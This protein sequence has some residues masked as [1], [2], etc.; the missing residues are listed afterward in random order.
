MGDSGASLSLK[1]RE[2]E[3]PKGAIGNSRGLSPGSP[4]NRG[5][6]QRLSALHRVVLKPWSALPGTWILA[7]ISPRPPVPVQ[8]HQWQS[9]VVGPDGNPRPPECAK[10]VPFP[11]AG[12]ASGPA[13]RSVLGNAP[14]VG[15]G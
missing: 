14:P 7:A 15:S 8:P 9:P 13:L 12:A 4:G 2:A 5:T 3:A 10:D 11:P 6:R 1:E